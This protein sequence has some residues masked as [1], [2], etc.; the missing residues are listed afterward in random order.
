MSRHY[1]A[2]IVVVFA[3]LVSENQLMRRGRG[4]VAP[5]KNLAP[6]PLRGEGNGSYFALVL[7]HFMKHQFIVHRVA[8]FI[9]GSAP[10]Q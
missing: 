1:T 5:V 10:P 4:A 9:S 8:P 3:F 6:L 7:A 2:V